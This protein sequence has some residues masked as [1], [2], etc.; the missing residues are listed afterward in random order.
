MIKNK[1]QLKYTQ[2]RLNELEKNLVEI[3]KKY[4][5]DKRKAELLSQGY[6]EHVA[7]LKAEIAE[8]ERMEKKPLPKMLWIHDLSEVS[9][10]LVRLR[11][12]RKLTQAQLAAR[13]GCKQAD[14]SRLEC[15]DYS[16][17]TLGQLKKIVT[18]LNAELEIALVPK[19]PR[20]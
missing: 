13:I 1:R 10:Q 5:P 6:K 18:S 17:H 14:I 4:A 19:T 11:I 2:K 8:F 15:E 16:G 12:A 7:Q 3:H 9:H 20:H